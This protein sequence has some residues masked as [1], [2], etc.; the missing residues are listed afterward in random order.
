[1]SQAEVLQAVE[2][3]P[4]P[5]IQLPATQ[6]VLL[7]HGFKQHYQLTE[8]YAIPSTNHDHELLVRSSTIGLNPIDWK[9]P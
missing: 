6:K 1:M 8:G 3:A 9:A 5:D 4:T 2:A 7:L